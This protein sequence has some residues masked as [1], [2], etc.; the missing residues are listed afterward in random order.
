ME[1]RLKKILDAMPDM[2]F[3]M[4]RDGVFLDVKAARDFDPILP[5]GDFLGKRMADLLPEE[6]HTEA[7]KLVGEALEV[8]EETLFEY[9]LPDG[10]GLRHYE[11]RIVPLEV[12][13]VLVIV[14]DVT[15]RFKAEAIVIESE[16]RYRRLFDRNPVPMYIYDV[17]SLRILDVNEAMVSCYG[18]SRQELGRMSMMDIRPSE[19]SRDVLAHLSQLEPG[20]LYTGVWRHRKKDGSVIDVD[21]TSADFPFGNRRARLVLCQDVTEKLRMERE[22]RESE[23]RYRRLFENN[24]LPMIIF[25]PESLEILAVNEAAERQYGWSCE[26]FLKMTVLDIR[27]EED[28]DAAAKR[29]EDVPEGLDRV[30][31]WRH[32]RKDG[33]VIYVDITSHS[34]D[35][36]GKKARMAL[37]HDVT[38]KIRSERRIKASLEEKEILLKEIHHRVK[39]NLQVISGLLHLQSHY[40]S[41]ES[42]KGIYRDSQNRVISMA[43]IHESLYQKEDLAR[44]DFADY[45]RSLVGNLSATYGVEGN[46]IATRMDVEDVQLVVDTAIPCGLI[47][48]ELVTNALK[49]AFPDGSKGV[50]SIEFHQVDRQCYHLVISDNGSGFPEDVDFRNTNTLGLQ[51]VTIL[52]DQLGGT[53]DLDRDGGTTFRISFTQYLEAGSEMH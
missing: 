24:P 22:L 50:V 34:L 26:E 3:L 21:I 11:A 48:N 18:Y 37:C 7:L 28:A 38:E 15:D 32:T 27:P 40:I 36:Q 25:D 44:V 53:I 2:Y 49:H 33:T 52:V 35:Y 43:L 46:R 45:I 5:P 4:D 39:N 30:G 12:Q 41:D 31:V 13:E 20:M 14:R 42:V 29:I 10:G 16:A 23:E 9:S 17:Q 6:I 8:G 47:I 51:L 1:D 19:E